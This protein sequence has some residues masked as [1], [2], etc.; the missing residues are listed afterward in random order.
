VQEYLIVRVGEVAHDDA[1]AIQLSAVERMLHAGPDTLSA[2]GRALRTT[3]ED[4]GVIPIVDLG[5][6]LFDA[7][8]IPDDGVYVIVRIED[9]ASFRRLALRVR[10]LDGVSRGQVR[11][12][13]DHAQTESLRGFLMDRRKLV[14]VLDIERLAA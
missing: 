10:E 4:D 12:V 5:Q 14:G 6:Q 11:Y 9:G 7:K 2:H 3:E 13:P 1:I 8:V